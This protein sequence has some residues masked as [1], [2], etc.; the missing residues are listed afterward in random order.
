MKIGNTLYVKNAKEWRLWLEKNYLDKKE[1]WL[2]YPRKNSNLPGIRYN[3]AVEEALCFGWI[4]STLKPLDDKRIAQRFTPRNPKSSY[5]Q[6]NKE[7]LLILKKQDK[8]IPEVLEKVKFII[9]EKFVFPEKILR[10]IKSNKTAWKNFQNFPESYKRVR[11]AYI[12]SAKSDEEQFQKR[13]N[14]FIK[15]TENNKKFGFFIE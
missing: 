3:N 15:K 13:L 11:I 7:R 4:D 10:E 1:I 8:I 12:E 14:N 2:I 5:S 6:P 9:N